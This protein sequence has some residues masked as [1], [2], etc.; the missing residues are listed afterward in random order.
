DWEQ[1]TARFRGG[2]EHYLLSAVLDRLTPRESSNRR[3]EPRFRTTYGA[4]DGAEAKV[5]FERF[6]QLAERVADW[7]GKTRDWRKL[8]QLRSNLRQSC[9]KLRLG[10]LG[11]FYRG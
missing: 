2:D 1:D 11:S 5:G 6:S 4:T 3:F 7:L 8:R 9:R 10:G